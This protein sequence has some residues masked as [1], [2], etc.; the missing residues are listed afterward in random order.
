M[1][2]ENSQQPN[3]DPV[4][5][6]NGVL[7]SSSGPTSKI[8]AGNA[9]SNGNGTFNSTQIQST[10]PS[11][12][13]SGNVTSQ[14][15]I[16][17][18]SGSNAPAQ[19]TQSSAA[20]IANVQLD[21]GDT[22]DDSA[23]GDNGD[24]SD[25]SDSGGDSD[26]SDSGNNSDAGDSDDDSGHGNSG[27]DV[28]P[29]TTRSAH[30]DN[31]NAAETAHDDDHSTDHSRPTDATDSDDS[32]D[33]STMTHIQK[34]EATASPSS[35]GT[36]GSAGNGDDSDSD[37]QD[38]S[39]DNQDGS[40]DDQGG[41]SYDDSTMTTVFMT[42]SRMKKIQASQTASPTAAH[43][44]HVAPTVGLPS[45]GAKDNGVDASDTLADD[46]A[47]SP[48]NTGRSPGVDGTDGVKLANAGVPQFQS[49]VSPT[50]LYATLVALWAL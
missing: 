11:A 14:P 31:G 33:R 24:D 49:S 35:S 17:T 32:K 41:D 13:A 47:P 9:T 6:G 16:P 15:L 5:W 43:A 39:S 38:G 30:D 50:W 40:S 20:A 34:V 4:P 45:Q 19:P 48:S 22:S 36:G 12:T 25:R 7:V 8:I 44:S 18:T 29:T 46:S 28:D 21:H 1:P 37:S 3:G 2:P 23:H 26:H 10:A 27:N 42:S